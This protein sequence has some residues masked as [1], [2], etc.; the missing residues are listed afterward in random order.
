MCQDTVSAYLDT[1]IA[2]LTQ[3]C[4][5]QQSCDTSGNFA[6][7]YCYR[8]F[9]PRQ[10]DDRFLADLASSAGSTVPTVPASG[11]GLKLFRLQ[12][13]PH[14]RLAT[15]VAITGICAR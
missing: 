1:V 6:E 15:L 14:H 3:T 13:R 12:S 11:R 2:R 4:H 9:L 7:C 10:N 8:L 5:A